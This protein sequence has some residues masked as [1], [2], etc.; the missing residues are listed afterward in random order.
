VALDR[1]QV[2]KTALELMERV[3]LDGVTLR[4]LATELGVQ[5]PALYWHF[6]N[7]QD[8]L[9]QMAEYLVRHEVPPVRALEPGEDWGEWL[10]RRVRAMHRSLSGRRDGALLAAST[11][12]RATQWGQI[13]TQV[14]ILCA[15]GFTPAQALRGMFALSNYVAGFALEEQ[16]DRRRDEVDPEDMAGFLAQLE[17]YPRLWEAIREIGDPQSDG[18]FEYGLQLIISGMR[19]ELASPGG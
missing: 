10:A 13:E 3:G 19:A 6:R 18:N 14:D 2:V 16:A 12:P 9:D 11:K 7:K 4:R 8:L 17:A 15:A 1:E 5:A